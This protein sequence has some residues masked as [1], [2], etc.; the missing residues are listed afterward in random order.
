M[1]EPSLQQHQPQQPPQ[2]NTSPQTRQNNINSKCPLADNLQLALCLPQYRAAP[3][4][5]FFGE[6]D[7]QKF[8]MSCEAAI[9]SFGGDETTL[10]K[11][12]IISLKNT[13][14]NWYARL[15]PRSITSWAHLKEKFLVNFQDFQTDLNTEEDFFSCQQYERETLPDFFNRFLRLKVQTPE[16]SN[17]QAL[18]QAIKALHTG[19]LHSHL[20]RECPR[21]LEELYEEFCKH[22]NRA[23]MRDQKGSTRPEGT[24]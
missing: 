2:Q 8:L 16:V 1:Q 11:S 23:R 17:E 10:T 22:A 15:P 13:A 9:A 21:T 24:R 19:Q 4:P 3:P 6:S 7:P 14:A 20:V 12:F 18:T 5:K